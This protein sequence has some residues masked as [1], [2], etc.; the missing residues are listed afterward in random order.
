M[1]TVVFSPFSLPS[2]FLNLPSVPGSIPPLLYI[3]GQTS[4][5]YQS[6]MEYQ[7]VIKQSTSSHVKAGQGNPV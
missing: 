2:P 3:K 7:I 6:N 4:L 5:W 1:I